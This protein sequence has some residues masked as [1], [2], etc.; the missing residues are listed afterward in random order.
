MSFRA[1]SSKRS[2]LTQIF[3]G[4]CVDFEVAH[5]SVFM[6]WR[7]PYP[8]VPTLK[9]VLSLHFHYSSKLLIPQVTLF[10]MSALYIIWRVA[11]SL[12]NLEEMF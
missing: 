7:L 10:N 9:E 3:V 4:S 1:F 5:L 6:V 2:S 8:E 12:N 11:H